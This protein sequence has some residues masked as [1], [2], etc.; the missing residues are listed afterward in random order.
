[1]YMC[2]LPC[3]LPPPPALPWVAPPLRS[4]HPFAPAAVTA[5]P[6]GKRQSAQ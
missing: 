6:C 3:H 4:G 5:A 2:S 1:M